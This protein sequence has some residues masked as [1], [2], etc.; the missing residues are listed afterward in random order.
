M[1]FVPQE[2]INQLKDNKDN[3]LKINE[4][5]ISKINNLLIFF[6]KVSQIY[7]SFENINHNFSEDSYGNIQFSLN[8][9]GF[10]TSHNEFFNSMI[11][12]GKKIKNDILNPLENYIKQLNDEYFNKINSIDKIILSLQN[13]NNRIENLKKLYYNEYEIVEKM[14]KE[15]IKTA[16]K[17]VSSK[18]INDLHNKLLKQRGIMENKSLLYRKEINIANQLYSDYE[19]NY[20]NIL[21]ELGKIEEKKRNFIR[22]IIKKYLDSFLNSIKYFNSMLNIFEKN[23]NQYDILKDITEFKKNSTKNYPILNNKWNIFIFQSYD[24]YKSEQNNIININDINDINGNDY[25]EEDEA[26]KSL[27]LGIESGQLMKVGNIEKI[28]SET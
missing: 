7:S 8:I 3:L 18:E 12:I 11:N 5:N 25:Y 16:N 17:N 21:N 19:N 1:N 13:Q 10:Y 6:E 9:Q 24:K 23:I 4:M 27:I 15:S 28:S 26:L 22:N 14:E 20:K 2:L